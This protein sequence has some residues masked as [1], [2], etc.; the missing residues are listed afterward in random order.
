MI[1]ELEYLQETYD[2]DLSYGVEL[3]I[4]I[5]G[6]GREVFGRNVG[7]PEVYNGLGLR[8]GVELGVEKGLFSKHLCETVADIH[9]VS[10]DAWAAYKGYREHVSQEKL[11]TFYEKATQRLSPYNCDIIRGYSMDV[12]KTFNDETFD[13]V[14]LDGNHD[15]VNIANDIV[16][17]EKKV[18]VG[19]IVS[20]HDYRRFKPRKNY[21]CHV[22]EVVQAYTRAHRILT[23]FII[24]GDRSPSW[25]WVKQ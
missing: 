14:Y 5:D 8:Y 12:V 1:N 20:G 22:F 18:R 21:K 15:F 19:G 16:E 2:L 13:F 6:N 4:E 7:I 3:P 24:T 10:I 11:E 25:F 9:L 23:W 17:W